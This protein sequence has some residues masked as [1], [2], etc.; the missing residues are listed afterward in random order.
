VRHAGAGSDETV[1]VVVALDERRLRLEV[2]DGGSE[3]EP[4][5]AA[6]RPDDPGGFGLRLVEQL[7]ADWGVAHDGDGITRVWCEVPVDPGAQPS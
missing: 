3:S 5:V 2:V 7:A 6:R 1:V 4:H